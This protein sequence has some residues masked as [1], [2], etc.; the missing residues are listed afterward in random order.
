MLLRCLP[1]LGLL[2]G[3]AVAFM[4]ALAPA[5]GADRPPAAVLSA[6]P[7]GAHGLVLVN[8]LTG[9]SDRVHEFGQ[10]FDVPAPLPLPMLKAM[11]G[12]S[13][14]LNDEGSAAMAWFPGTDGD[15][16][17][18]L[19]VPVSDYAKFLR[20]L[21][22]AD[23][24]AETTSVLV[25]GR[26]MVA[27]RKGDYAVL[28]ESGD[29]DTLKQALAAESSVTAALEPLAA[30]LGSQDVAAVGFE[31]GI[32][33]AIAAG[34]AGLQ[35][36]KAIFEAMPE[37]QAAAVKSVFGVYETLF[38]WVEREVGMAALG[39]VIDP[40]A[41]VQVQAKALWSKSGTLAARTWEPSPPA[42]GLLADIRR[43][44]P[45]VVAMAGTFNQ[46]LV[47]ALTQFSAEIV[48]ATGQMTNLSKEDARQLAE[49]SSAG[50]RGVRSMTMLMGVPD[51]GGT[52]YSNTVAVMK[53]ADANG[54]IES[55]RKASE[56][57]GRLAAKANS[58]YL[59]QVTVRPLDL[60]GVKGLRV[61]T[62]VP[63]D[64]QGEAL[65]PIFES[66][67]GPGGKVTAFMAPKGNDTVVTA[68]NRR[69]LRQLLEAAGPPEPSLA[70]DE[71][72]AETVRMLPADA[73][74]LMLIN[75]RGLMDLSMFMVKAFL[76]DAGGLLP[77][78]EFPDTPPLGLAFGAGREGWLLHVAVPKGLIAGAKQFGR[79]LNTLPLKERQ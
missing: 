39:V 36:A 55:Q 65:V 51:E 52:I 18:L 66:M 20:A 60:D 29:E 13:A 47:E 61:T 57:L 79:Q 19:F 44:Q 76:P 25:A 26:Q 41:G 35:Q 17:G 64:Q 4:T 3:C 77:Q 23:P 31:R 14:G 62:T 32:K 12:I 43:V 16:V 45:F 37:E 72:I 1:G 70:D 56:E 63:L 69:L 58:R 54:Y 42:A 59:G 67:F 75:P 78:G 50:M 24:L 34:R 68:Y 2:V 49:A 73:Q 22:P 48:V 74:G 46:E 33:T 30:W 53:V 71:S 8:S 28:A 27:G 38:D 7:G 5:Q 40:L 9:L 11:A 6:V 21:N 10:Q 15:Q